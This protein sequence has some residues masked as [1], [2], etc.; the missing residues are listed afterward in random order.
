MSTTATPGLELFQPTMHGNW[1]PRRALTLSAARRRTAFVRVLRFAFIAGIFALLAL[2]AVQLFLGASS[3]PAIPDEA[4]STDVRMVNPRITGR[5]E[6][7]TPYALTADVAIRRRDN[8]DGLTEL[9]R[10]RL[11][12]D[13]LNTGANASEVLAQTGTF[14]PTNRILD[15]YSDVNLNTD[16]G[17]SFASQH[18]RIYLREERV[19]GEMPVTGSGPVGTITAER[20]EIH[21]GGNRVIFE[22]NVHARIVQARTAPSEGEDQ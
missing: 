8:A 3:G 11:D 16:N 20:Y 7:L 18:A 12:Y 21:E 2:L 1:E 22:G 13:F 4:V 14:D 17:Y 5:D 10:P 15:L 9:E 19:V 6:N